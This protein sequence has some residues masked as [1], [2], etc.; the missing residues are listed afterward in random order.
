MY[1]T[2][3]NEIVNLH[4]VFLFLGL[5]ESKCIELRVKVLSYEKKNLTVTSQSLF[6]VST[7]ASI[8]LPVQSLH[9]EKCIKFRNGTCI[10]GWMVAWY[11]CQIKMVSTMNWG[12]PFLDHIFRFTNRINKFV[13]AF[14]GVIFFKKIL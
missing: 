12:L 7:L 3:I 4:L 13:N 10:C 11:L 8:N 2:Y 6:E 5:G 9:F 1:I 14:C